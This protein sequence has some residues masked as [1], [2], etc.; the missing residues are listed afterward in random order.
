V[1][2]TRSALGSASPSDRLARNVPFRA[3]R[4]VGAAA[5][6]LTFPGEHV[7][8]QGAV[9]VTAIKVQLSDSE[10]L[11]RDV[12]LQRGSALILWTVWLASLQLPR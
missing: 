7:V 9:D 10:P 11:S 2:R 1:L 5:D 4:K 6:N 8:L 12:F 3:N